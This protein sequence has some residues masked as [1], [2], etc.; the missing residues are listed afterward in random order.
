MVCRNGTP[1]GSRL[2]EGEDQTSRIVHLAVLEYGRARQ[3]SLLEFGKQLEGLVTRQQAGAGDLP[4]AVADRGV[5]A[6]GQQVIGEHAGSQKR[7][8]LAAMPVG[9]NGNGQGIDQVRCNAKQR[10]ALG[11][12]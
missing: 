4:G 8:A 11:A 1:G 6:R 7:L 12:R 5:F 2:D 9:G 3:G 10:R